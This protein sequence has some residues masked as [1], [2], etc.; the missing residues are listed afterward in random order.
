[1]IDRNAH[2]KFDE[3]AQGHLPHLGSRIPKPL[4]H[5]AYHLPIQ[6]LILWS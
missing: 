4:S 6:H 5:Q 3:N 1:M 2:T